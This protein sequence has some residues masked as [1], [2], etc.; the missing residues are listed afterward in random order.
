MDIP[1]RALAALSFTTLAPRARAQAIIERPAR[2]LLGS[3]PGGATDTTAR[4]LAAEL[5]PRYAPQVQVENRPGASARLG[6]EALRGAVA[7]GSVMHFGPLPVLTLFPH[8]MARTTRYNPF[9]DFVPV[10]TLGLM[11]FVWVVRAEHPARDLRGFLDG[12]P[13][14]EGNFAP[15]VVGTPQHLMG[16]SI[17]ARAGV[18]LTAISYRG[19]VLAHPDL[20]A[21]RIDS[22]INQLGD[23][24]EHLRAGRMRALAVSTQHRLAWLPQTPTFAES[25]FPGLPEDEASILLLPAGAPRAMVEALHAAV[26]EAGRS[27]ALLEGLARLNVTPNILAPDAAAARL[28]EESAGFA[29]LV[30][31]T[32]FTVE[33]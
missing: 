15:N 14:R 11:P 16:L 32:G 29:G 18:R 2:M 7:D 33:E 8:V 3:A 21:G 12:L 1:R 26:A 30:R 25:G 6:L 5:R 13:G 9:T 24:A 28:R 19:A 4:L 20:L 27:P 10:A 17:A 22:A 23:V 31:Q